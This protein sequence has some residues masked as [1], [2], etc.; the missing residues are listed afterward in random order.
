MGHFISPV[1]KP[2]E[3]YLVISKPCF[4]LKYFIVLRG[5]TSHDSAISVKGICFIDKR[6]SPV[7]IKL[8]MVKYEEKLMKSVLTI[9]KEKKKFIV[10][11]T[12]TLG[13]IFL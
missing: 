13:I 6:Q 3:M 5:Q 11:N 10:T 4:L 12:G 2:F 9:K 7:D 1:L 8:A